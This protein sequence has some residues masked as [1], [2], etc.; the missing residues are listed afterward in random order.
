[1][2]V[3]PSAKPLILVPVIKV[4]LSSSHL[5]YYWLYL[6]RAPCFFTLV[7]DSIKVLVDIVATRF[8]PDQG[9]STGSCA[10]RDGS[11]ADTRSAQF[12]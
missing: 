9:I 10:L 11:Q 1:M 12:P 5:I 6:V 7:R 4:L 3:A 8:K 2:Q